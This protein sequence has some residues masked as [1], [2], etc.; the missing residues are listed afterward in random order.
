MKVDSTYYVE[1]NEVSNIDF[2]LSTVCNLKC[3]D[4]F[5]SIQGK[6]DPYYINK[7]DFI[8]IIK[9]YP[10]LKTVSFGGVE[11]EPTLHPDFLL[12]VKYLKIQKIKIIIYTNGDTN[13][14]IFWKDLANILD[15]N[16][17]INFSISGCTQEIHEKY[18][19]N[20][21]LDNV[22]NNMKVFYNNTKAK[23][24]LQYLLFDYNKKDV[25]NIENIKNYNE[26]IIINGYNTS[27]IFG[28][29]SAKKCNMIECGSLISL[30]IF[31]DYF[32]N[33]YPCFVWR[34]QNR[35][36]D[37]NYIPIKEQRY[38]CCKYFCGSENGKNLR[39]DRPWSN[40][41]FYHYD[42]KNDNTVYKYDNMGSDFE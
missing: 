31:V 7:K 13:N 2:E 38:D 29:D 18:R 4:C 28:N 20:S 42:D 35:S 12:F 5:R 10:N 11:S 17:E 27:I 32:G 14:D 39:N 19:V 30:S 21:K 1:L 40:D 34:D 9:R 15:K 41:Y 36:F 33:E 23:T 24:V 8:E 16:D 6:N 25:E 26:Y 37:R 3:P 22:L